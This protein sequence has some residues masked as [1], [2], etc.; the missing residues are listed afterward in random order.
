[1]TTTPVPVTTAP[2]P[3]T[4]APVPVTT[5]PVPATTAR[6]EK[7]DGSHCDLGVGVY[8]AGWN[9]GPVGARSD[10][11][12]ILDM[13]PSCAGH[14]QIKQIT[15]PTGF[16]VIVYACAHDL[17]RTP[18]ECQSWLLLEGTHTHSWGLSA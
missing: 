17:V 5:A 2:V 1:M 13:P 4:T 16:D 12:W 8:A 14:D 11:P 18:K 9:P 6:F 10:Y 15:V 3:V 7:G